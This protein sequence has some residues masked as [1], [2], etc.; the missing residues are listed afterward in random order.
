MTFFYKI[1]YIICLFILCNS[2]VFA[3]LPSDYK[4]LEA[5]QKSA[6]LWNNIV[7]SHYQDALPEADTSGW[8]VVIKKLKSIL[9]LG[10]TFDHSSDEIPTG[11]LKII[12]ATGAVGKIKFIPDPNHPF[13]GIY[14]RGGIGLARFS[15]AV[16]PSDS[17]YT[18]G[19]AL[20]FL[21]SGQP[22]RNIV[23]MNSLEGQGSNWNFFAN[24]F[25]NQIEHAQ[26]IPLK[27]AECIFEWIRKPAND[28]PIYHLATIESNGHLVKM[29]F[30][31]ERLIFKPSDNVKN[32]IPS[33]SRE[34][35]RLSLKSLPYGD[36]YDVYGVLDHKNIF[37]GR[38]TLESEILAS[39]YGD[40]ELFFQ[41]KR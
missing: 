15:L 32:I 25:S 2:T 33:Y 20:K 12:H 8:N 6:I 19:I 21:I 14:S 9:S 10:K 4:S 34:D 38:I 16:N 30:S 3:N 17:N 29:P 39:N 13:T 37:I 36:L 31:P 5:E 23:A 41:H 35:F 28:L 11:R 22:S 18:P 27:I 24:N 7:D 40:R 26:T 1:K